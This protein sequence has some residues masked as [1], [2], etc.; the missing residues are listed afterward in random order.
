[1]SRFRQGHQVVV[2]IESQ[3]WR[4]SIVRIAL[5]PRKKLARAMNI[6]Q[7]GGQQ[8]IP[9]LLKHMSCQNF[10]DDD[11]LIKPLIHDIFCLDRRYSP[12]VRDLRFTT[13]DLAPQALHRVPMKKNDGLFF[14][15]FFGGIFRT[16]PKSNLQ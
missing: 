1:M 6:N 8:F 3:W 9:S 15:I 7:N 2:I 11:G 16:S 13:L 10:Q 12:Q 4:M 5:L 14:H